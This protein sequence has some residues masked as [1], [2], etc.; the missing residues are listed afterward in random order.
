MVKMKFPGKKSLKIR[1]LKFQKFKTVLFWGS[2]RS[3]F[4]ESLKGFKSDL[5]DHWDHDQA[6]FWY[7]TV[8]CFH[9]LY[10]TYVRP[11]LEHCVQAWSPYP[12][13]DVTLLEKI[14]KRATKLVKGLESLPYERRLHHLNLYF[15]EQRRIIGDLIGVF[16]LM[17]K[18]GYLPADQFFKRATTIP[19]QLRGHSRKLYKE[20]SRTQL[21]QNFFTQRV[22]TSNQWNRLPLRVINTNTV[23]SFKAA[24]DKYWYELRHGHMKGQ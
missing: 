1:N 5:R 13:K 22:V 17:H 4:R 2:L 23:V 6:V 14:Q 21:C 24:L 11:H 8:E 18:E 15:L 9:I 10:N 16:K 19:Q 3:K 12:Q 7:I 20:Q